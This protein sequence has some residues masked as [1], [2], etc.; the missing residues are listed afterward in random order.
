MHFEFS[1]DQR[2]LR[3]HGKAEQRDPSVTEGLTP[4]PS[5]GVQDLGGLDVVQAG[6]KGVGFAV[7]IEIAIGQHGVAEFRPKLCIPC[8]FGIR[9]AFASMQENER[10]MAAPVIGAKQF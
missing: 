9:P 7:A 10:Q 8:E 5:D 6:G 4:H 2:Q 1:D 3:S